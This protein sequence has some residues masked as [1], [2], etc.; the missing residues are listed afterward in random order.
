MQAPIVID[1]GS[2][3]CRAGFAD[4]TLPRVTIQTLIARPSEQIIKIAPQ[5]KDQYLV[6]A[7]AFEKRG[8]FKL[9]HPVQ[10]GVIIDWSG[11][12]HLWRRV[13]EKDLQGSEQHRALVLTES[14][15]QSSEDRQKVLDILFNDL[16][17]PSVYIQDTASLALHAS[18]LA[19]GVV[20]D[21]GC[22]TTTCVAIS[23]GSILRETLQSTSF[24]GKALTEFFTLELMNRGAATWSTTAEI[25]RANEIREQVCFVK[26]SSDEAEVPPVTVDALGENVVIEKEQWTP[27]EALFNPGLAGSDAPGIDRLV[28]DAISKAPEALRSTLFQNIVLVGGTSKVKGLAARLNQELVH[29]AP[30]GVTVN[31]VNDQA[32]AGIAA[33]VGAARLALSNHDKLEG[34]WITKDTSMLD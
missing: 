15:T 7:E 27:G 14:P 4:D 32:T 19:T 11:I 18:G 12:V 16:K 22:D 17:V 20:L 30:E 6:G 1:T 28:V 29:S 23:D 34:K 2:A 31:V 21:L 25:V 13:Y 33:W 10:D 8:T 3:T 26:L 9:K 5:F 24:A